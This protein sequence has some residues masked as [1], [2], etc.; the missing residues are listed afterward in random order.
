M[1]H[2]SAL[3]RFIIVSDNVYQMVFDFKNICVWLSL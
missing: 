1:T 3:S 2:F